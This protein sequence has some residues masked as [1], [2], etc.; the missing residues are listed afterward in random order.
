MGH[1]AVGQPI[2]QDEFVDPFIAVAVVP[3]A[4]HKSV[5][6]AA[7]IQEVLLEIVGFIVQPREPIIPGIA[8]NGVGTGPAIKVIVASAT[9]EPVGIVASGQRIVSGA[10]KES[11][12]P[13][14]AKEEVTAEMTG[15]LV[16]VG[17]AG[18]I[19]GTVAAVNAVVPGTPEH[20]VVATA[21]PD[22]ITTGPGVYCVIPIPAVDQVIA[23]KPVDPIIGC[24]PGQNLV[25]VGADDSPI[26]GPE[27]ITVVRGRHAAGFIGVKIIEKGAGS[28]VGTVF[29]FGG[30]IIV[31]AAV[32]LSGQD[33]IG[34]HA[35]H[36]NP[37][38][39]EYREH[40]ATLNR[41]ARRRS[42]SYPLT[43]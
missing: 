9:G 39:P 33:N 24:A 11:V 28:D 35:G 16:V 20:A 41:A 31:F 13:S 15:K 10:A 37:Q 42:L 7:A 29:R 5:V 27:V 19:V 40:A 26:H 34:R 17:P 14:V 38:K 23:A 32:I 1:A 3:S 25:A 18:Q 36:Q 22:R 8:V 6:P 12:I 43:I 4:K 2:M 21:C 30:R